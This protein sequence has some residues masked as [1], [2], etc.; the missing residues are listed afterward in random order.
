MNSKKYCQNCSLIYIDIPYKISAIMKRALRLFSR[1]QLD[2]KLLVTEYADDKINSYILINN[3]LNLISSVDYKFSDKD[4][5]HD[6]SAIGGI[7]KMALSSAVKRKLYDYYENDLTQKDVDLFTSFYFNRYKTN[8]KR[9][10]R[11]VEIDGMGIRLQEFIDILELDINLSKAEQE[12]L[13]RDLNSK[14]DISTEQLVGTLV[15]NEYYLPNMSTE[16]ILSYIANVINAYG[17]TKSL[18]AMSFIYGYLVNQRNEQVET[19]VEERK[20][21]FKMYSST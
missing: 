6:L 15:D 20:S 9:K 2:N 7:H 3:K 4:N 11:T 10:I 21:G 8:D 17:M 19:K 18:P 14:L 5:D 16:K 1:K 13:E 12:K